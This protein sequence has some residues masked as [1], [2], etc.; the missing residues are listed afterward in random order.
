MPRTLWLRLVVL[1]VVILAT[2]F[3]LAA[4][5]AS[6]QEARAPETASQS[7]PVSVALTTAISYQGRLQSNGAAVNAACDFVFSLFDD[8]TA[9]VPIGGNVTATLAVT[10]GLFTAPLDFG[11]GVFNGQGRWLAT[12]VRCPAGSGGYTTLQP[13]QPLLPASYA[14]SLPAF[15]TQPG[16]FAP[17]VLGNP[18]QNTLPVTVS[19][20]VIGGGTANSVLGNYATA[21]G[22]ANNTASG[23]YATVGG[24]ITNTASGAFATV[25]GGQ[26]NTASGWYATAGGGYNSAASGAF[27]TVGGGY[28]SAAS[29]LFSTVGGGYN[30]AAQG[31]YSYAAGYNAVSQQ[32][33]CFTWADSQP[34]GFSCGLANAFS[35]RTTGGVYFV[36]AVDGGGATTAGVQVPAGGNSWSALSDRN[37][38]M[39]LTTVDGRAILAQVA[40]MPVTT[41]SYKTQDAS[42]RHMGPM[43]QDVYAAFGLGEDERHINT[44]DADGIA[45]AAIQALAQITDAQA[46]RIAALEAQGAGAR[47]AERPAE[48]AVLNS[49][50]LPALLGGIGLS[51]GA[52]LLLGTGWARTRRQ[53]AR[54]EQRLAAIEAMVNGC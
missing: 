36:T 11:V 33:G 17:S 13:R 18:V 34:Y 26:K 24:G 46:A 29:G 50:L 49:A 8:A 28:S 41:W 35:A 43:A 7:A 22:G 52:C 21:S 44:I 1:A 51:L 53:A 37:A 9:G 23:L 2:V 42:I 27:S 20:G 54:L 30:S 19:G 25:G 3:G 32:P 31:D 4:L 47:V 16:P 48:A 12:Q 45:L 38:K 5:S 40:A 15:T 14:L 10:G 6:A 39:N